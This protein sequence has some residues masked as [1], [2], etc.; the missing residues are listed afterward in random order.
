MVSIKYCLINL[1]PTQ[2]SRNRSHSH[3]ALNGYYRQHLV[4]QINGTGEWTN[5][6]AFKSHLVGKTIIIMYGWNDPDR[7]QFFNVI[8]INP[9]EI[10]LGRIPP[11]VLSEVYPNRWS[12]TNPSR[13]VSLTY[14]HWH[15]TICFMGLDLRF[16]RVYLCGQYSKMGFKTFCKIGW[17]GK[18]N[19]ITHFTY[20][21]ISH[22]YNLFCPFNSNIP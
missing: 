10:I 9:D 16:D 5:V 14:Q 6:R 18:P 11:Y 4:G 1:S 19:L 22:F 2:G 13:R 21:G 3:R 20:I 8:S 17:R 15:I 12:L 7:V